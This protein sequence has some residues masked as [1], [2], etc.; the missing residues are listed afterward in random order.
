MNYKGKCLSGKEKVNEKLKNLSLNLQQL[1]ALTDDQILARFKDSAFVMKLKQ[2]TLKT[3][4]S[5]ENDQF[6]KKYVKCPKCKAPIDKFDGCNK[7]SC[8]CGC[9]LCYVCGQKISGYEHFQENNAKCNLW[10]NT[11]ALN[12]INERPRHEVRKNVQLFLN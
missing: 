9:I 10:S 1:L 3:I 12:R 7:I 4:Q 5:E 8:I 2:T 6:M 11:A